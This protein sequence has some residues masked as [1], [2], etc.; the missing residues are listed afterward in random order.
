MMV[1]TPNNYDMVCRMANQFAFGNTRST[2][3][4]L[5][6]SAGIDGL[7]KA[8]EG[9]TEDK[10]ATENGKATFN[11][12]AY[13]CVLNAMINEKIRL[14]CGVKEDEQ[15]DVATVD[16]VFEELQDDDMTEVVRM[17]IKKF[18]KKGRDQKMAEAYF[19]IDTPA[20]ELKDIAENFGVSHECVRLVVKNVKQHIKLNP[21]IKEMLYDFVG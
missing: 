8:L 7:K 6:K 9:Y 1:I 12:F 4:E 19:G 10:E 11:T 14:E 18:S 3:F 5:F 20:Q 15:V 16:G 17:L 21:R 2:I 13:R